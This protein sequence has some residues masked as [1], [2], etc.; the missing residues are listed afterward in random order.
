MYIYP[1]VR[2]R[3]ASRLKQRKNFWK[4][5]FEG[6]CYGRL[7]GDD[8]NYKLLPAPAVYLHGALPTFC[9]LWQAFSGTISYMLI[10]RTA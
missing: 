6:H 5:F 9:I 8:S 10:L 3:K 1:S 7:I 4:N 2:R